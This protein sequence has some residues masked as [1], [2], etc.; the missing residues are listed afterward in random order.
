MII[1]VLGVVYIYMYVCVRV[2]LYTCCEAKMN[3]KLSAP[4]ETLLV[5]INDD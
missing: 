4:G 2:C 3:N 5:K 1:T